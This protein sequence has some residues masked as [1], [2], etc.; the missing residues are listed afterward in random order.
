MFKFIL[1]RQISYINSLT[2]SDLHSCSFSHL[3]SSIRLSIC[4]MREIFQ[5]DKKLVFD[6]IQH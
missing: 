3:F 4:E 2:C 1:F 6:S 5:F